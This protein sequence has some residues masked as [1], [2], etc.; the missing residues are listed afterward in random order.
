LHVR[1]RSGVEILG[2]ITHI[3]RTVVR[4][5]LFGATDHSCGR[6][7]GQDVECRFFCTR[8]EWWRPVKYCNYCALHSLRMCH[9]WSGDKHLYISRWTPRSCVCDEWLPG[10]TGRSRKR[11]ATHSNP[12]GTGHTTQRRGACPCSGLNWGR[13]FSDSD[14]NPADSC[15]ESGS[16]RAESKHK[17]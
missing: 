3:K 4:S 17:R 14:Q 15:L 11:T 2:C 5:W 16:F 7:D 10:G 12:R 1:S 9:M 13:F 8:P 6:A